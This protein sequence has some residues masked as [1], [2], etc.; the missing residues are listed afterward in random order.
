[1]L[2]ISFCF[3]VV[4]ASA[5]FSIKRKLGTPAQSFLIQE[6]Y[7]DL[8]AFEKQLKMIE[9]SN[10]SVPPTLL[11]QIEESK[12]AI[13]AR[14]QTPE[15]IM[16]D[17]FINIMEFLEDG[18]SLTSKPMSEVNIDCNWR[19]KTDEKLKEIHHA[20]KKEEK[21]RM[22]EEKEE[23]MRQRLKSTKNMNLVFNETRAHKRCV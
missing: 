18:D 3:F 16:S 10:L 5:P 6:L 4:Y 23:F 13:S 14:E 19:M 1:M 7:H 22:E 15:F 17:N 11:A 12:K 20:R 9:F 8:A 2:S 21:T